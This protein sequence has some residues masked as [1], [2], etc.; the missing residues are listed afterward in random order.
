MLIDLLIIFVFILS[1]ALGYRRGICATLLSFA[2]FGLSVIMTLSLYN[3]YSDKFLKTEFGQT[4][5]QSISQGVDEYISALPDEGVNKIPFI[6]TEK[7]VLSKKSITKKSVNTIIT[8]LLLF[9]SYILS[10]L[11]IFAFKHFIKISRGLAVI[12]KADSLLGSV[13]GL[14]L[15]IIWVALIYISCGYASLL[16]TFT[17]VNEQF[18][19]SILIMFISD[20]I[21]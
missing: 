17:F 19:T 6:N 5:Q 10:K 12:R 7:S 4:I 16:S 18:N 3:A 15:G 8:L 14:F 13:G 11:I 20:F 9:G 1:V 2:A 21:I